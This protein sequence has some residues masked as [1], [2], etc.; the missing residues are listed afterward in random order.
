MC[1]IGRAIAFTGQVKR[2]K[3]L[4]VLGLVDE[5]ETDWKVLVVDVDD[6]LADKLHG[7][8]DVEAHLPGLLDATRDWF[9]VYKM[10]DGNPP[11]KY[12]FDG[13]FRDEKSDPLLPPC[14]V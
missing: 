6:P 12:A 2:V 10:P 13:K 4:G 14:F 11:N 9:R 5:G 1:E 7:I 3:A 8:A